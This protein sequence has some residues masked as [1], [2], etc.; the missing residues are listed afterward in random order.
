MSDLLHDLRYAVRTLRRAPGF[1]A[2]AIAVLALGI[3]TNTTMFTVLY[4]VLLRP[5][6]YPEPDR[7]VEL[8]Q[9]YQGN[10]GVQ[11]VSYMQYQF[12]ERHRDA[13]Q[14]VAA[15]TSVG[16]NLF[17]GEIADRVDGLRVSRDYFR[18][19]GVSPAFGR[20][21]LPE[22]D[23]PGGASVA[24]LSHGLWMRRFGGDSTVVG[25]TILLDGRPFTVV[26]VMPAGFQSI[27]AKD[28][29]S[30]I[31]QV[32]RSIGGGQNLEF[33][34][35][36][37]PG[38]SLEQ[39]RA[40]MQVTIAAFRREFSR[41]TPPSEVAMDLLP[42]QRLVVSDL[43]RPIGILFGAIAFVLLIACANVANLLL[44]RATARS[45]ELAVRT[46]IGATRGRL[47]RQLV[48]ESVSLA[49]MGGALGLALSV[50]A[51]RALLALVPVDLPRAGEL[52]LDWWALGFTALVS[53]VTGALF[54][55]VPARLTSVT[56]LHASLT[57]GARRT[58]VGARHGRLRGALVVAEVA[59]SLVLLVGAGLL[60][61]TFANLTRT[62]PGFKSDHVLTAEIWLTGSRYD[63]T[64][65]ITAFYDD[66]IS[67]VGALPGVR[68]AAVVEAGL[69]L[70]RGGNMPVWL[71]G[72]MLH[73][74]VEYRTITPDYLAALDVPL[75]Q[76]RMLTAADAGGAEPVLLVNR[77]FAHRFL[78]DT[79]AIGRRI[80]IFGGARRVVGVVGDIKSFVGAT[81]GPGVFLPT[82]QTP[83]GATRIFG[84]WFPI[85]VVVRTTT[86]P[87]TLRDA[88]ARTIHEADA[89]V[90]V[91]RVR[92]MDE[93]LSGTLTF[94]RFM[95]LLLGIF[96]GLALTLAAVGIYGVMSYFA[97][98]RTHEIGVRV[99]LGALPADVVRLV[100]RRGLLL[101]G[102]GVVVGLAGAGALTGL[103][104]NELY[105]VRP[106]D[107][108]TFAVVTIGLALLSLA[109]CA[110]P[111]FRAARLDPVEA[112][113][114]E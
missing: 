113:R 50:W 99:A 49:L 104:M 1:T 45:R 94:Q 42:Y 37:V 80:T 39:A 31:A 16:F 70:E 111:A 38:L 97:T 59:L 69:P 7:L 52:H 107:P 65:G 51:L 54:G 86:D 112:L 12:L 108:F 72:E 106:T 15:T 32:G 43:D 101:T 67:R 48:T 21:F 4:G 88:L 24:I 102:L 85:H 83:A 26:G 30:T 77:T 55:L 29:W 22:E 2:V 71:D 93:V 8:G 81:A 87:G 64:A 17:A 9:V 25:R 44:G 36:L 6:P 13:F 41:S 114:H 33:L 74:A 3:G 75:L 34:G 103:L 40:R 76:G 18:V 110:I 66:L 68:S 14:Y 60:I 105:D 109:A 91:G 28:I 95:M 56:N 61:K 84:S 100:L 35:R 10:Q 19:L 47:V 82:A 58:T 63:S 79:N 27:P 5:L 11:A 89:L 46:A 90:P 23:Q 57:E 92:T 62:D 20:E 53:V 73:T 98:Q 96:A 78:A